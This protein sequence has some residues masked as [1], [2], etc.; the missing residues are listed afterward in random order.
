LNG[1]GFNLLSVD[2]SKTSFIFTFHPLRVL[3]ICSLIALFYRSCPSNEGLRE[4]KEIQVKREMME[5]MEI[6]MRKQTYALFGVVRM[7]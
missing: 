5:K 1:F 7:A 6:E 2:T 3:F 4:D